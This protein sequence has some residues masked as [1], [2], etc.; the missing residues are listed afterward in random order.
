[1]ANEWSARA[2]Q[3][4]LRR[5]FP[6]ERLIVVSNREP[7]VHDLAAD[8]SIAERHPASGLV[9]ALDPVL[10]ASGGTWVAHGSG[11]ADRAT[12]DARDRVEVA[13]ASGAYTLRRVWLTRGEERGYYYGFANSGLWPLCHLAFEPPRFTRSDWRHYQDVNRRFADAVVAEAGS[14]RPVILVQDYHF[15][16]LPRLLRERLPDATIA[17]FWHIPWPNPARLARLPYRDAI[18]DGLLGSDVVGFQ[19]REHAA[20]FLDSVGAAI[21][22]PIDRES[23]LVCHP[24]GGVSAVRAY[25]ISIEWPSRWAADAPP[26]QECRRA[27]RS[28]LGVSEDAPMLL[29]VDRID[30]TKGIEERLNAIRRLLVRGNATVGRPVFVQIASPSRTR[31]ERYRDLHQRIRAQVQ[32]INARFGDDRYRPVVL[33]DRHVEPAH[34]FRFYRAANACHVGSLDDGMN[35][36]A[37][38]FVSARDDEQGVLTLSPFAGAADELSGAIRLNPFDV[39]GVADGIADALTMPPEEQARRMRGMRRH[40]AENNVYRWAA[41]LLADVAAARG[42]RAAPATD[43]SETQDLQAP[44]YRPDRMGSPRSLC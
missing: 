3:T 10:R 12:V 5:R 32:S 25:P 41:R 15:A 4:S 43:D 27:I 18:L 23:G 29:S 13:G 22:V 28:E 31:L 17:A 21:D 39:D 26:V 6:G 8:G 36:V 2:L 16:L 38:E 44:E 11:S 33:I 40:L 30:Y 7:C 24:S 37:K 19:T 35:L 14:A 1:V 42:L 20:N 9:T 34:V